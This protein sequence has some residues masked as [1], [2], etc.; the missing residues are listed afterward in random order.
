MLY[1]SYPLSIRR[2]W[3][4]KSCYFADCI[5]ARILH[6]DYVLPLKC[7]HMQFGRQESGASYPPPVEEASSPRCRCRQ[8]LDSMLHC[9]DAIFLGVKN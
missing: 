4:S 8:V 7:T 6:M 1:T 2:C 3:K 9:G 5:A